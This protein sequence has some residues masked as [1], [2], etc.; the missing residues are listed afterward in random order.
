MLIGNKITKLF[1]KINSSFNIFYIYFYFVHITLYYTLFAT[2]NK[3]LYLSIYLTDGSPIST[4][5]NRGAISSRESSDL[6]RALS[7]RVGPI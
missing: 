2:L 4:H 3:R 6:A 5:R 1:D 7:Q